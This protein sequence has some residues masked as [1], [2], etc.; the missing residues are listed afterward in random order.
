MRSASS[1]APEPLFLPGSRGRLFAVHHPPQTKTVNGCFLYVAPFAEEMNRCRQ[2]ASLQARRFAELGYATLLLDLW[3]TGDS[4]GEY[5]DASWDAWKDDLR[6]G[7]EWLGARGYRHCVLWGVRQG[8]LLALEVARD[9]SPP[10]RLLLWQP[11]LSGQVALN[12]ILRIEAASA[13][14]GGSNLNTKELR[15]R[16]LGGATVEL[17]GYEIPGALAGALERARVADHFALPELR[18]RWFD[19]LASKEE[20]PSR[21]SVDAR[22]RWEAA[23]A[24]VDYETVVGPAFW[25]V[26]ERVLAVDLLERTSALAADI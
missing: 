10:R 8:A 2:M 14:T 9:L 19:V 26:W 4:E 1:A 12:Q 5:R 23:G 25:Q 7:V 18:V 6:V 22:A 3:G 11:T 13:M 20:E 24:R 15:E 17:S 16:M 21:A